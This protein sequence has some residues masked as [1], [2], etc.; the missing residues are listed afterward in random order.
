MTGLAIT[1]TAGYRNTDLRPAKRDNPS[2]ASSSNAATH[3]AA[4]VG[5][6]L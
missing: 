6:D 2:S 1:E 4:A 3:N 5:N